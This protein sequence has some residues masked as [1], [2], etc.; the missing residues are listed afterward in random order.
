[1]PKGTKGFAYL[2]FYV[3]THKLHLHL[4]LLIILCQP[5]TENNFPIFGYIENI[6][7][8]A[9]ENVSSF[10]HSDE[11]TFTPLTH[12]ENMVFLVLGKIG[13]GGDIS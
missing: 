9:Q 8:F 7:H 6:F 4:T 12:P 1:M 11:S 10:L 3:I 13:N 2:S 5:K